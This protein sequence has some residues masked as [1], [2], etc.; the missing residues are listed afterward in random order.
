ML[1]ISRE[2]GFNGP[3]FGCN[4]DD[5]YQI[6][7]IAGKEAA[8]DFFIHQI[9]LDSPDMTPIIKEIAKRAKAKYG[10][11]YGMHIWGFNPLYELKQVIEAAQSVDP[12]DIKDAWEKIPADL[13]PKLLEIGHEYGKKISVEIRR[14]D[15]EVDRP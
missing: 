13:R 9:D 8:T 5:A 3:V 7:E 12:T 15:A 6:R 11:A 2:M 10:K 4:Y 1:K 14:M